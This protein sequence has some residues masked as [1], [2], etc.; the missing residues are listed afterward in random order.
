MTN[1][2]CFEIAVDPHVKKG[3]S[4]AST[5]GGSKLQ[6]RARLWCISPPL[7]SVPLWCIDDKISL[8]IDQSQS[9]VSSGLV[10]S[11]TF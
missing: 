2:V 4:R 1:F 3:V 11:S 9:C 10:L 8:F 5:S 7:S 6:F